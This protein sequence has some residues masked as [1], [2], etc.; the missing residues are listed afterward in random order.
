MKN[1]TNLR[2]S[3]VLLA[4]GVFFAAQAVFAAPQ[5]VPAGPN[6]LPETCYL[7]SYFVGKSEDGLHL[8]WST[9]GL[10]WQAL[11]GGRGSLKPEVGESKLMRDP[12]LLRGPDGVFHLVWTTSW[13]GK[14]IGYASSRDLIHWTPQRAIPVM[15]N[16][17]AVIDTWAP[18]LVCDAAKQNFLIVWSSSIKGRYDDTH[19]AYSTTTKDFETFSPATL[20][21]DPGFNDIDTTLVPFGKKFVLIFKDEREGEG[22]KKLKTVTADSLAGPWSPASEPI[23][24]VRAEGPTWLKVGDAYVVY[25]DVFEKHY[26]G[27]LRTKDFVTYENIT[28]QLDLPKGIRHGTALPVPRDIVRGLLEAEPLAPAEPA[29]TK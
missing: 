21:F 5:D 3:A 28:D 13:K 18:E 11:N 7:F 1:P 9:D 14:T 12:S 16:E 10:K 15:E 2:R 26:Y 4:L 22:R 8:A 6:A 23:S 19:R 29:P 25:Y 27:A 24:P 17:P 20:F